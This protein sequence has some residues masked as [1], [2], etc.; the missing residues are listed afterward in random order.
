MLG[1]RIIRGLHITR[2]EG[3]YNNDKCLDRC[4][5]RSYGNEDVGV[6]DPNS[7]LP[8]LS[9]DAQVDCILAISDDSGTYHGLTISGH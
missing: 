1:G 6:I 5:D 9:C 2:T 7:D 4:Q 8:D 3:S